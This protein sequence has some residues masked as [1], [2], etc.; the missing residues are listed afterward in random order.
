MRYAYPYPAIIQQTAGIEIY[1]NLP[2]VAFFTPGGP[3]GDADDNGLIAE[4]LIAGCCI[5]RQ[6]HLRMGRRLQG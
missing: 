2:K 5:R 4:G 1:L 3:R 6:G